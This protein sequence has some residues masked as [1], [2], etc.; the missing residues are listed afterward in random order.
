LDENTCQNLQAGGWCR[1]LRSLMHHLETLSLDD[2]SKL[3]YLPKSIPMCSKFHGVE[4][5]KGS[6]GLF[7]GSD[8]PIIYLAFCRNTALHLGICDSNLQI[9][10]PKRN[11]HLWMA[12]PSSSLFSLAP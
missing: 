9:I 6:Y 10:P 12:Y 11:T 8:L 2:D 3:V 1:T 4:V 5:T 7:Q